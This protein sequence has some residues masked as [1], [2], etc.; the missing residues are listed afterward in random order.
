MKIFFNISMES[1]LKS[2]RRV[3]REYTIYEISINPDTPVKL[4]IMLKCILVY[5]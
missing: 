2:I 5:I 3:S 4:T 1:F